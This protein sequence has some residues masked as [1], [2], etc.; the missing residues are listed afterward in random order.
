VNHA[1]LHYPYVA[2]AGDSALARGDL[3][4]VAHAVSR[5]LAEGE[6]RPIVVLDAGNSQVV[7]LDLRGSESEIA[8]RAAAA[9]APADSEPGT[10]PDRA[11][12]P[13]RPRL[14]VVSREISL[15]PRHWEWLQTQRGGASAALRRLV[16]EARR[17]GGARDRLVASQEA[18]DRYLRV[19]AG[20]RPH[21]EEAL[22]AFYAGR[23]ADMRTYTRLWPAD[24]RAHLDVLLR[25]CRETEAS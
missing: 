15:L 20:D 18:V 10:V 12:G 11:I 24:I 3:P 6:T 25:R 8:A 23:E 1:D 7:D 16:D 14:G 9:S 19:M 4:S 22:R 2:F 13:G 17:H 21:Y 5:A